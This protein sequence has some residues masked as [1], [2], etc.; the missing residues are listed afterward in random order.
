M[1]IDQSRIKGKKEKL[2][3]GSLLLQ[4][5]RILEELGGALS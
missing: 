3:W 5:V 2:A 4:N 1:F